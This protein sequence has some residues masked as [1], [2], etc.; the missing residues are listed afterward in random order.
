MFLS[1][2]YALHLC[3][4]QEDK[5][6]NL[7]KMK[8]LSTEASFSAQ[9]SKRYS[10]LSATL[11]FFTALSWWWIYWSNQISW[12]QWLQDLRELNLLLS[13]Y[14]CEGHESHNQ[15]QI[16]YHMFMICISYIYHMFVMF[17]SCLFST[18]PL[19]LSFTLTVC[20]L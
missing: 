11:V 9:F 5:K 1:C 15:I 20:L 3:C 18:V 17:M 12:I 7:T 19:R 16:V 14:C 10:H 8:W 6:I 13:E 2:T 4:Y